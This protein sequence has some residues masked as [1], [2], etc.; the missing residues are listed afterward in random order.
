VTAG[1]G[2]F[3]ETIEDVIQTDAAINKGNSGG[4]LLNLKG[5]VIGINTATVLDA[6]NIS[7]S[8]PVN[9]AKRDIEQVKGSGKITYPFI[10]VYYTLITKELKEKYPDSIILIV[11][12]RATQYGLETLIENKVKL[13]FHGR[14]E[15]ESLKGL[16]AMTE[17]G[18]TGNVSSNFKKSVVS[19]MIEML[20]NICYHGVDLDDNSTDKPGLIMIC[21]DEHCYSMITANYI[22]NKNIDKFNKH[23]AHINSLDEDGLDELYNEVIMQ[24]DRVGELGAGLGLID[25][26]F[27]TRNKVDTNIIKLSDTRS[28]LIVKSYILFE[29]NN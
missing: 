1:G 13:F 8:I 5:E 18:I 14:F 12:H 23:V 20:Q 25:L 9:K 15:H 19:V 17:K 24:E 26:R 11:G 16:I 22:D 4:P 28:F 2:S 27:K 29:D 10:G 7:F 6:Q 3:V 21:E